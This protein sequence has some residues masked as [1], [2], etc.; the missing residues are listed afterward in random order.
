MNNDTNLY[1]QRNILIRNFLIFSRLAPLVTSLFGSI[2]FNKIF[3][4]SPNLINLDTI[5]IFISLYLVLFVFI[6]HTKNLCEHLA[7]VNQKINDYDKS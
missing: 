3:L 4:K 7:I 2:L 1:S 5:V 6:S